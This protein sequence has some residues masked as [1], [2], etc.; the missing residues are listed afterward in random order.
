MRT[1]KNHPFITSLERL[2][3]AKDRAALA[4]LRRGLGKKMGTPEM[5]PY[6]VPYL[7]DA[8]RDHER[9]F[10]IA[11]L[12]AMHPDKAPPDFSLGSAFR[13][14][15]KGSDSIEKRFTNLLSTEAEDIGNHLRHAVSLAKS[16]N[17]PIDYHQLLYDLKNWD[18]PDRFVQLRWAKDF[19]GTGKQ[20]D[21]NI[22]MKGEEE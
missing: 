11:A 1:P 14:M 4:H 20:G 7:P 5:L 18:H 16:R 3:D 10:L 19:W 6:V 13:R 21:N 9:Y 8:V 17:V 2:R 12:F 15:W 22:R